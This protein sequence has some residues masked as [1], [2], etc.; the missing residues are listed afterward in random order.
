MHSTYAVL[1]F[2]SFRPSLA[3]L[4]DA[5][6]LS[7]THY[8]YI[9]IYRSNEVLKVPCTNG[10]LV[11]STRAVGSIAELDLSSKNSTSLDF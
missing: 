5:S 8:L 10:C 2:N 11:S 4:L 9:Y 1:E 6:N 3:T 7:T